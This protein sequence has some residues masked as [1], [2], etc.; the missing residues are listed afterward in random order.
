VGF[1]L[2]DISPAKTPV[3]L[4]VPRALVVEARRLAKQ[5]DQSLSDVM[6]RLLRLGLAVEKRTQ[7]N[8]AA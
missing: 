5:D 2:A 7:G 3:T 1:T 8:E 6:R 4:L